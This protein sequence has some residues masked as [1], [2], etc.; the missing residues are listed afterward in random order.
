MSKKLILTDK[1]IT[2]TNY[3]AQVEPRPMGVLIEGARIVRVAPAEDFAA[4]RQDPAVEQIDAG[5][6]HVLPG[7]ID[8][9]LHLSFSAGQQPVD[10]LTTDTQEQV[11][12]R[13]V[14]AAQQELRSGVT[15]VRDCG[16]KG[17]AIMELKR[18][19]DGGVLQGPNIITCGMPITI[20]GGHCNFCDLE[21]DSRDEVV[22]AVR[23]LCKQGVDFIK[24]MVS[25]G[26]MTPGSNSL[27]DQYGYET[28]EAIVKEAHERGKKVSGHIHSVVGIE[29]AVRAGF[30]SIEHCAFKTADGYEYRPDLV[31]QMVAKHI[32]VNPAFSKSYVLPPELAAP[33]PDKIGMWSAFVQGRFDT[34]ERM[35]RAGVTVTAGTDAG[36]KN[37]KF[38]EFWQ[39]LLVMEEKTHMTRADVLLSAACLPAREFGFAESLGSLEPGKLADLIFVSGNPLEDLASLGRVNT[40]IKSGRRVYR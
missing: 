39:T 37:T 40:V 38:D 4:E 12:L 27:I 18:F 30:D 32:S 33:Q 16:A 25:G 21:C 7:L 9:H 11:M 5:D 36:C 3:T 17:M 23:W 14:A 6:S 10:Q 35:Y 22:K 34:M 1:L 20:T 15:T 26:N 29:N 2:C 19:I 8:G 13:M 24:V 31:E 28:L